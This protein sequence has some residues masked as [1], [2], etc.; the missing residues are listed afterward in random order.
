VNEDSV[1]EYELCGNNAE[2]PQKT[3]YSRGRSIH[4]EFHTEGGKILN[5]TYKGFTGKFAFIDSSKCRK[6]VI[7]RFSDCCSTTLITMKA[8]SMSHL[9][10]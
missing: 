8:N 4:M 5:N 1:H 6:D 7:P 3:F 2:L 10:F 9:F